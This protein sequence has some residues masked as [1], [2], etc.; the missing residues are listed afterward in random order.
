MRTVRSFA[1]GTGLES[2]RTGL[3]PVRHDVSRQYSAVTR[4][5]VTRGSRAVPVFRLMRRRTAYALGGRLPSE[6]ARGLRGAERESS[7]LLEHAGVNGKIL[8]ALQP[9][10]PAGA[11]HSNDSKPGRLR[12]LEDGQ[13]ADAGCRVGTAAKRQDLH[14]DHAA[15]AADSGEEAELPFHHLRPADLWCSAA[16]PMIK[17]MS[18]FRSPRIAF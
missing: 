17:W 11:A 2:R 4:N 9:N 7:K 16:S 5:V 3:P 13:R 14:C 8:L 12:E 1:F 15:V 10:A 6:Q 18:G